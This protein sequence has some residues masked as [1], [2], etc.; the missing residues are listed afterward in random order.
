[1]ISGP[2]IDIVRYALRIEQR[3][4]E[5]SNN[6]LKV[7]FTTRE[8]REGLVHRKASSQDIFHQTQRVISL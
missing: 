6:S 1:M 2:R 7:L 4:I 8:E 3:V 5:G